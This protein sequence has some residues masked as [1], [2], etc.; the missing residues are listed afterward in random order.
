[1]VASHIEKAYKLPGREERVV[2]LRDINISHDSEIVKK[3]SHFPKRLYRGRGHVGSLTKMFLGG[4]IQ[5][6]TLCL[7]VVAT[8]M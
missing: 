8:C 6:H 7:P 3:P 5:K 4:T 1:V 2:A